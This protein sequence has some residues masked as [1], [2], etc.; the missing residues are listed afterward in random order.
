[1][2]QY[3][4]KKHLC[5]KCGLSF[6]CKY[7]EKDDDLIMFKGF[8]IIPLFCKCK[9]K[10]KKKDNIIIMVYYCKNKHDKYNSDDSEDEVPMEV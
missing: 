3:N 7:E 2:N 6:P 1:M 10:L 9:Q 8:P 4:N 5:E